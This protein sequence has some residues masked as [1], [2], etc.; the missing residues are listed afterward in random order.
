MERGKSM[1]ESNLS[2]PIP[3]DIQHIKNMINEISTVGKD[4]LRPHMDMLKKAL[5]ENEA[6]CRIILPE[7]IG[8]LVKGIEQLENKSVFDAKVKAEKKTMKKEAK[9]GNKNIILNLDEIPDDE[10]L[11]ITH[12]A[13]VFSVL[14]LIC[15]LS[16]LALWCIILWA[17]YK[18]DEKLYYDVIFAGNI[19]IPITISIGSIAGFLI[20][21]LGTQPS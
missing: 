11:M 7:E 20:L 8:A 19:G 10:L 18:K 17:E 2:A 4:N 3:V 1:N 12:L 15:L 13:V 9:T 5:K 6:A 16:T 14:T 21:V